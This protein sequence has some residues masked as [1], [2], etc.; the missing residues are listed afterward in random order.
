[1]D[2]NMRFRELIDNKLNIEGVPL[3]V[4]ARDTGIPNT[5]LHYY[6]TTDRVPIKKTL[7]KLSRYFNVT[8]EQLLEEDAHD[9]IKKLDDIH[10]QSSAKGKTEQEER[11]LQDFRRADRIDRLM[12]LRMTELAAGGNRK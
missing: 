6:C 4:L 1:M 5:S 11:L 7:D 12:I 8:V 3:D 2:I 10:P 9:I